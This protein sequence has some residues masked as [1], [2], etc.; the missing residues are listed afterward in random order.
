MLGLS[1]STVHQSRC[2]SAFLYSICLLFSRI[3]P[4]ILLRLGDLGLLH[5]FL[6]AI[7]RY[8]FNLFFYRGYFQRAYELKIYGLLIALKKAQMAGVECQAELRTL[9]LFSQPDVLAVMPGVYG[10]E[11]N[12]LSHL[13]TVKLQATVAVERERSSFYMVGP[14]AD[15]YQVDIGSADYLVLTKPIDRKYLPEDKKLILILNNTYVLRNSTAVAEYCRQVNPA[16]VFSRQDIPGVNTL[17]AEEAIPEFSKPA[18][19]MGFQRALCILDYWFEIE[20]IW[21]EGFDFSVGSEP[22]G[23]WYP[24]LLG[25]DFSE[26]YTGLVVSNM[27]HDI[28]VNI[29]WVRSFVSKKGEECNGLAFDIAEEDIWSSLRSFGKV[30]GRYREVKCLF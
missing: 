9:S 18:A 10:K 3:P 14:A 12:A 30:I 4:G 17:W 5:R 20:N 8:G 2:V 29:L 16:F 6:L 21:S 19:L 23:Q 24:S 1:A 28:A 7:S 27:I 22:Y 13:L 11:I 25:E 15:I 26:F